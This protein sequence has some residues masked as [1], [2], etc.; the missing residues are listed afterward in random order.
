LIYDEILKIALDTL[1]ILAARENLSPNPYGSFEFSE[2]YFSIY[3]I[4]LY[5][6]KYN[7]TNYWRT[8]S[9][10]ELLGW[11]AHK[12][13]IETHLKVA[14]RKL[15]RDKLNTFK[16]RPTDEGLKVTE[17]PEPGYTAPRFSQGLRIL[18]DIGTIETGSQKS[19]FKLTNLGKRL[20]G[21]TIGN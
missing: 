2:N 21:E 5:S 15:R 8:L 11:L 20:L 9:L 19:S 12:W 1:I 17:V 18:R 3:P 7:I 4:N 16:I 6:F 13:G 14:L 10:Q